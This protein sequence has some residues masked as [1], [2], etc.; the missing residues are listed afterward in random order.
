MAAHPKSDEIEILL[1]AGHPVEEVASRLSCSVRWVNAVAQVRSLPRNL[2]ILPHSKLE[3]QI[4]RALI[5]TRN[6]YQAVGAL[7]S[8]SPSRLQALVSSLRAS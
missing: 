5:A 4:L 3:A 7:F 2:P 8:Q 6:N 1:R